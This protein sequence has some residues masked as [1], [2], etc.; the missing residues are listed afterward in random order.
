MWLL[1]FA[2]PKIKQGLKERLETLERLEGIERSL[3]GSK[4][5]YS[6]VSSV[7]E[8]L[9]LLPVLEKLAERSPELTFVLSYFSPSLSLFMIGKKNPF[10]HVFAYPGDSTSEV[11]RLLEVLHPSAVVFSKFDLWPNLINE[12][13]KR[14]IPLY[15]VSA[16]LRE[17]S[18]RNRF[19]RFFYQGL[20][21]KFSAIFSVSQKD[22]ERISLASSQPIE[23]HTCGDTRVDS[24]YSRAQSEVQ[25]LPAWIEPFL[26]TQRQ[27]RLI[28]GS[29]W[30]LDAELITQSLVELGRAGK[31]LPFCI[32]AP[33]ECDAESLKTIEELFTRQGLTWQRWADLEKQPGGPLA[34]QTAAPLDILLIDR[35]GLLVALYSLGNFAFV[36]SG[37]GGVHNIM[38]PLQAGLGV[39]FGPRYHNA[40]EAIELLAL[41]AV[42]SVKTAR[43]LENELSGFIFDPNLSANRARIGQKFLENQRGAATYCADLIRKGIRDLHV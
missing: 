5:I 27:P 19:F 37:A 25:K 8:Y 13:W 14:K 43:E 21:Q 39:L 32:W 20:Y 30:P 7:G 24:V 33:H 11:G 17:G 29:S 36:G 42:K 28:I 4:V 6:H 23:I 10:A 31:G 2:N 22:S 38:E 9:Q 26:A 15:L 34:D 16:T 41:G 18:L 40:P 35:V 3:A 12:C 1:S